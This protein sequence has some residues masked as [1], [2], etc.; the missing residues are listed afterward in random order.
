M[1]SSMLYIELHSWLE[2]SYQSADIR[3]C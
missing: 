2:Y 1:K 3:C